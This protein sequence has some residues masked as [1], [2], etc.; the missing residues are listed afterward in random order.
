M[1]TPISVQQVTE[2][3]E[4]LVKTP[5][6]SNNEGQVRR[7]LENYLGNMGYK[8]SIDQVGNLIVE[9]PGT[10]GRTRGKPLL[11]NAHMD[12]VP[13]GLSCIPVVKD[14]IMYGDGKTNLGSDDAA[15]IAI[16]LL[17]IHALHER[18]LSHGPLL[19]LF[20]VA[21]EIGVKGAQAFQQEQ[22]G[23]TDGI[24]FDNAGE[25]GT[26]I[27]RGSAYIAFDVTLHGRTGHPA[28]ELSGTASAIEMFRKL[29][30]PLGIQD[31][32]NTRLSIGLIEGGSARNAIPDVLK[33]KGEMR[34]LLPIDGQ[35]RWKQHIKEAFDT[36]AAEYG[37]SAEVVFD[38]HGSAYEVDEKDP[39][40]Q[41][42]RR[43]WELRGEVFQTMWTFVGSDANALRSRMRVFT[44]STGAQ[45][46][47]TLAECI[48]L[49]PLV[50]IAEAAVTVAQEY[51]GL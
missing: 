27:M 29:D 41:L 18:K 17:A 30:L 25:P 39:L 16:I 51:N 47:H 32:G 44:V 4:A 1:T 13:P 3:M 5:S 23:V 7:F 12:R 20:T 2:I 19:L 35:E 9:V 14:G 15:G 34:T 6:T 42:Y 49:E 31:D 45:N 11:Y 37:G 43:A 50:K 33:L 48:R 46:E 22:W 24:I 8:T 28:K 38:S 21:E 36:V 10:L 40:L 26:V